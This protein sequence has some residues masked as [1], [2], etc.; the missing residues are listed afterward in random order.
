MNE[1]ESTAKAFVTVC[2]ER[3]RAEGAILTST[4]HR[5]L[6]AGLDFEISPI[7]KLPEYARLAKSVISAAADAI[8]DSY[9]GSGGPQFA[10]SLLLTS[11]VSGRSV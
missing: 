2:F 5:H 4:S 11:E 8:R 6:Q 9:Q 7:E 1:F 10:A 3:L